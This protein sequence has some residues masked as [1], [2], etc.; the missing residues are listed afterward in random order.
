MGAAEEN[1][2]RAFFGGHAGVPAKKKDER[3][4]GQLSAS[5]WQSMLES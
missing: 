4:I 3:I 1:F 2:E 5:M